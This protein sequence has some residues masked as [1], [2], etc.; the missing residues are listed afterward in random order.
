MN[1]QRKSYI[2]IYYTDKKK[3]YL[4]TKKEILC[5][6][7]QYIWTLKA[8]KQGKV[9]YV[10]AKLLQLC[11]TLCD[12]MNHSPPGSSVHGISRQE[13][14]SGLSRPPPGDLPDPGIKSTS[15]LSP[16]LA[17]EFFTTSTTW[18]AKK[19]RWWKTNSVW[20]HLHLEPKKGQTHRH[21]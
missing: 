21:Q 11:L 20:S 6:L 17:S 13:Y 7:E 3:Y 16:A 9:R 2:C 15:L 5:L 12:P 10:H 8:V 1:G 19:G 14:W 4:D 18:E